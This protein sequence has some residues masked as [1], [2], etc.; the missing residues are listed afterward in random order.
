MSFLVIVLQAFAQL[1]AYG[2]IDRYFDVRFGINKCS[3]DSV[4]GFYLFR[5]IFWCVHLR[6]FN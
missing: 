3:L 2:I 4:Y 1:P 6:N 5:V